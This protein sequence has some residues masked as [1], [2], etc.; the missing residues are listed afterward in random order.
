MNVD[1]FCSLSFH[2]F[3]SCTHF[4][5]P[6]ALTCIMYVFKINEFKVGTR[7]YAVAR[8]ASLLKDNFCISWVLG[9]ATDVNKR[10]ILPSPIVLFR[11]FVP[12]QHVRTIRPVFA[13]PSI[14]S[15]LACIPSKIVSSFFCPSV[16]HR[17]ENRIFRIMMSEWTWQLNLCLT[18]P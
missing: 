18:F 2:C 8:P 10:R 3:S 7:Y 15:L 6:I 4:C 14:R 13:P 1:K 9:A 11:C 16:W 17:D 12:L 5:W